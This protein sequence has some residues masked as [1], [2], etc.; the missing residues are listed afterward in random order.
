MATAGKMAGT[1][2]LVYVSG[3][4]ISYSTSG[5]IEFSADSRETTNKDDGAFK[6]SAITLLSGTGSCD[7]LVDMGATQGFSELYAL[8]IAR[9]PVVIKFATAVAGDIYYTGNAN[10][11]SM[12]MDAPDKDNAT[13]SMS[14]EWT[15]TI[16]EAITT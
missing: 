16:T 9:S 15:G 7:G 6:S 13:Y 1:L 11:T 8:M 2:W 3:T 5:S 14:F 12:S 10:I 4:A